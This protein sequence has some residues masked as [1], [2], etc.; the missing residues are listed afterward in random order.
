MKLTLVNYADSLAL[1][2]NDG[3]GRYK[4][5]L[6]TDS[7]HCAHCGFERLF[8]LLVFRNDIGE[9]VGSKLNVDVKGVAVVLTVNYNL[10]VGCVALIEKH[11][12]DLAR[13]YVYTADDH[14]VVASA[15]RLAHLNKS[16]A[17]GAF[18]ALENADIACSVAEKREG[19]LVK[20]GEYKLALAALGEHL[21]CVG[22]DDL[23]IEVVLVD[24][25]SALL[26]TL[27]RNAGA[28]CFCETVDIIRLDSE[29]LFD[30]LTHF[31]CPGLRS[32]DTCL[33]LVVLRLVALLCECFAY[34]RRV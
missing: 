33:E 24:V 26:L 28:A 25:H 29:A 12:F 11:G 4:V 19:F 10:I 5:N 31:L 22:I 23:G 3:L 9:L 21:A 15:H 27:K 34:V 6:G 20:S 2:A 7:D 16:S 30:A 14:H 8:L 32:E 13:E 18:F 17:A 1:A